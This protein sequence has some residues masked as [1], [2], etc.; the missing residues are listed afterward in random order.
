MSPSI[1]T[2]LKINLKPAH[3]YQIGFY[4]SLEYKITKLLTIYSV[5]EKIF[6][7]WTVVG[8]QVLLKVI[9]F[10][11][12]FRVKKKSFFICLFGFSPLFYFACIAKYIYRNH[13]REIVWWWVFAER[14]SISQPK[15]V[16]ALQKSFKM[17]WMV[18]ENLF[19]CVTSST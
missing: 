15:F 17:K 2:Y 19:I 13:S 8:G 7:N 11:H 5:L 1:L 9:H 16:V 14:N 3:L 10:C 6:L 18:N 4:S 12:T